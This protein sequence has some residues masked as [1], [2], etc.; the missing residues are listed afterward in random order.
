MGE[1]TG[2]SVGYWTWTETQL[3]RWLELQEEPR[4]HKQVAAEVLDNTTARTF[5]YLHNLSLKNRRASA[6]DLEEGL[7]VETGDSLWRISVEDTAR[8][9]PLRTASKKKKPLLTKQHQAATLNL[10]KE[11]EKK[12]DDCLRH[13]L[14]SEETKINMFGPDVRCGSDQDHHR[15]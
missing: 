9:R 3:Q 13:V 7:S 14:W 8:S 12:P 15:D 11:H 6:S 1:D 4:N 10:A 2:A 5:H